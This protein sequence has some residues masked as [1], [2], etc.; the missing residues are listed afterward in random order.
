MKKIV[1]VK[2]ILSFALIV[3]SVA[4]KAQQNNLA[5]AVAWKQS[6]AEHVAL[7]HQ[8]FNIAKLQVEQAI[9]DV[10]KQQKPLAIISDV[11]ETLLLAD[12]YWAYM[13]ANGRDF[14]DDA[15]WDLWVKED[16]FSASPAITA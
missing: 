13:I 8:G 15:V 5:Y 11:D 7:Y 2:Y 16:L 6:A 1:L 12:S 4:I 9:N 10:N 3:T 14:F